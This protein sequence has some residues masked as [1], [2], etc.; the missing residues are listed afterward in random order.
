LFALQL[1]AQT[2]RPPQP[3]PKPADPFLTSPIP[4][5]LENVTAF[6]EKIQDGTLPNDK[7]L[8][9]AIRNRKV[10]F[11]L[12]ADTESLLRTAGASEQ[13][14]DLIRK[15]SPPPPPDPTGSL[16]VRCAPAECTVLVKGQPV[17]STVGG[18]LTAKELPVGQ[19]VVDL[20]KAGYIGVQRKAAIVAD[21]NTQ[22]EVELE[23]DAALKAAF[24]KQLLAT[25]LEKLGVA[26]VLES[27]Y[28]TGTATVHSPK[29]ESSDWE[30]TQAY[31]PGKAVTFEL[32]AAKTT[33]EMRCAAGDCTFKSG[34]S[35]GPEFDNIEAGLR[36][37]LKYGFPAVQARI[38]SAKLTPAARS[39][40]G[41][42]FRLTGE[43]ESFEVILGADGL[44]V[45]V[46]SIARDGAQTV[47]TYGHFVKL[48]EFQYPLE[49]EVSG[50]AVKL[51]QVE[52]GAKPKEKRGLRLKK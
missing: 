14:L 28:G 20:K 2:R 42:S 16:T 38:R 19:T 24:G 5:K 1:A 7:R 41:P 52:P 9:E 36:I 25:M 34:K 44:P 18:R 23:P 26:V 12:T 39:A 10:D 49:T 13:L 4:L 37:L 27:F 43:D 32:K 50:L 30:F 33:L 40:E 47:V 21:G 11:P 15:V 8:S 29:G 22:L 48:G 51:S 17:G 35:K 31:A 3:P 46:T 45:R 6:L